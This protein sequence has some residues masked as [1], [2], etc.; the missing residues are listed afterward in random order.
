[1]VS[2]EIMLPLELTVVGEKL[3]VAPLGNP[4]QLNETFV[5]DVKPLVG[6]KVSVSVPFDPSVIVIDGKLKV[7]VKPGSGPVAA[8]LVVAAA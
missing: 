4:K 8:P 3:H 1:M 2:V 6:V 7:R 5:V